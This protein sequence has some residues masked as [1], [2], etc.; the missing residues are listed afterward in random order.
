MMNVLFPISPRRAE[1]LCFSGESIKY[2]AAMPLSCR[3]ISGIAAKTVGHSSAKH[4]FAARQTALIFSILT[5][6]ALFTGFVGAQTP[7]PTPEPTPVQPTFATPLKPMPDSSRVGVNTADPLSLSLTD[8]I[9]MALKNNNDIDVSRNDAQIADFNLKAAKGIYD[10]FFNSQTFYESRTTPTA[11][12]IGGAVNGSVTQRQFFNDIGLSGFVPKFGGSYDVI[13]NQARTNTTN[14]NTT[15]NPQF[16]TNLVGTYTQPLWRGLRIDA[17]RRNIMIA[18]K[19]VEISGSQ[20]RVKAADSITAVEQAYWDLVFALRFLQVQ[21]DTLAQ[22][23]EQLESNKRLVDKGVLAPIEIVAAEA[24]I[25]TFEQ[26]IFTAQE[27]ITR[28]ENV[29]KTLLLPDRSSPEWSRPITPVTTTN[30]DI[31]RIGVE[32]ATAE[33]MKNRP[34]IEQLETTAEINKIDQRF[35]KDQTKPQID[36]VGSY[37]AAGLAGTP[38]PLSSGAA[39]VPPNLVGGYGTSLGNL[40]ALDYPTYR[41]GVQIGLPLR[42]R[43]AK[44]NFGRSLVEGDRIAN[45]RAQTE[46][47]VEAEVRNALQALRSAESRLASA[48]AGRVA[49]EELLASEQRQFRAGTTTFYLVRQR[50]T[51]LA[52]ARSLELRAQTDLNKAVSEFQ[53]SIGATLTVN[54]VSVSK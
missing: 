40:A 34:E 12:T 18:G 46:Q 38:N 32:V 13:F 22:A 25:A 47:V 5:C 17:N 53:R 10:P 48:T 35:Y 31:P 21:N 9:D 28:A 50:T 19:N 54:N 36:L 51:D 43:T 45:N 11:S 26:T 29:L 14:R 15:L 2:L 37:T 1:K 6:A 52:L 41:V 23:R 44:A 39:N 3:K 42:N 30:P 8:A 27:S 33:A 4:S 20:L 16:P 7:T 24:Q 49:A